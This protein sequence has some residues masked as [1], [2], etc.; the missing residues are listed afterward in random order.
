MNSAA[1]VMFSCIRDAY[2]EDLQSGGVATES[3]DH[4]SGARA[5][6]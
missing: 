3:A 6:S 5:T 4:G 2:E 1:T